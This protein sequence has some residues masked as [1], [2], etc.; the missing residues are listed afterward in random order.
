MVRCLPI[1]SNEVQVNAK[2]V[3]GV[4]KSLQAHLIH[5]P[6]SG[7]QAF[8]NF[9]VKLIPVEPFWLLNEDIFSKG[10]ASRSRIIKLP[11]L[12]EYIMKN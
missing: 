10:I 2:E 4:K 12:F 6:K 9:P 7:L 5:G 8:Q 3:G 11:F 1:L